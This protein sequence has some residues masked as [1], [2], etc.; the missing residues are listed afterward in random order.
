MKLRA[1]TLAG[2]A[3][4]G[5]LAFASPAAAATEFGSHCRGEIGGPPL[6]LVSISHGGSE[7]LPVAAPSNGVITSWGLNVD[8][9]EIPPEALEEIVGLVAPRLQV[10]RPDGGP[11]YTLVGDLGA[12]RLANGEN[13]FSARIPVQAGDHLGTTGLLTTVI[14]E[15]NDSGDTIGFNEDELSI[16]GSGNFETADEVQLPIWARV[17]AD[18]DGDGYG[19]ETQDG[20]PQSAAYH[21]A[22]P[23]VT[24]GS[25]AY[26]G[27]KKVTVY[28]ATSLG[29]PVSVSGSVAIGKGKSATLAG[30][31]QPVVPGQ[32]AKFTLSLPQ[33]VLKQLGTT[34]RSKK[35]KA[36]VT[37]A[38]TN[39]N[40]SLSSTAAT[41]KLPG[42]QKPAPKHK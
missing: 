21:S 8:L 22:C 18:A 11:V 38:A 3:V 28:V 4:C 12:P 37:A 39:V 32:L 36:T 35:L 14:C 2:L 19:D 40:G 6:N 26:A 30:T 13:A 42:Q 34:P 10:W 31:V 15:S 9:S 23:V 16:G 33:A 17:E 1:L 24:I 27:K 41:V 7:P 29:A 20:C 5:V 25:A